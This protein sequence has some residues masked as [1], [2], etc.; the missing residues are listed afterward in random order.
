MRRV[1]AGEGALFM[2]KQRRLDQAR[3]DGGAVEDHKGLLS[4]GPP[5]VQRL[6]QHFLAGPGLAFNHQRDVRGSQPLAQRIDATH[7]GARTQQASEAIDARQRGRQLREHRL[8]GERGLA[9]P[10]D[11]SA[12]EVAVEEP[13]P[14]DEGPVGGAEVGYSQALCLERES[15]VTA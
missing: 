5:F 11:F 15:D 13:D 8:H 9:D 3:R 1:G 7:A 4:A 6:G 10:H 12:P 14:V 2:A